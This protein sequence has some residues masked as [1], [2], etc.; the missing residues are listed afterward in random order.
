M[1][2]MTLLAGC[3]I[4]ALA[5][6]TLTLPAQAATPAAKST[7]P[8]KPTI[9]LKAQKAEGRQM[10][11]TLIRTQQAYYLENSAFA[12]NLN[13]L[14][15][16]QN[17]LSKITSYR[18]QIRVVPNAGVMI[19]GQPTKSGLP[20]YLGLL[21]LTDSPNSN[22]AMTVAAVCESIRAQAVSP[23]SWNMIPKLKSNSFELAC[24]RGFKAL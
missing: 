1:R 17:D 23:P 6:A 19:I 11:G 10:T 3:T 13:D 2:L 15:G 4:V 5:S 8:K 12:T 18:Y 16:R 24:P 21:Q 14:V 9:G 22:E 7:A 20:T